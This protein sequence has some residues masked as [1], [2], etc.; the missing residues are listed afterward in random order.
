MVGFR[1]SYLVLL[2]CW[3]FG[4]LLNAAQDFTVRHEPQ[5]PLGVR[6]DYQVAISWPKD[7]TLKPAV[8]RMIMFSS[9]LKFKKSVKDL[10]D[11]QLWQI[12]H[13]AHAEMVADSKQYG[14]LPKDVPTAMVVLAFENEIFLAS[15]SK[16]AGIFAYEYPETKVLKT[17]Q[18]CQL[19]F[20]KEGFGSKTH[21]NRGNCGE[22]MV[23]QLYYSQGD[24]M[25]LL[26]TKS[27]RIAAVLL[28]K[29]DTSP[30]QTDPCGS[31]RDVS[32][33]PHSCTAHFT[34]AE[35]KNKQDVWGCNKFVVAEGMTPLDVGDTALPYDLE[36]LLGK[37]EISQIQLCGSPTAPS[38]S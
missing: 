19:E 34:K 31:D 32:E 38:S 15:S 13:D 7:I 11:G 37:P 5:G 12:A 2:V 4:V 8:R 16:N 1:V 6:L 22:V 23:A 24:D 28:N 18:L 36:E 30:T 10:S 21:K 29:G 35:S 3:G 17:L 27:A 20:E 14:I 26:A 25:P 9:H 33:P